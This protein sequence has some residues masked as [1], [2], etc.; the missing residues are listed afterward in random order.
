MCSKPS[1]NLPIFPDIRT[2]IPPLQPAPQT[3]RTPHSPPAPPFTPRILHPPPASPPFTPHTPAQTPPHSLTSPARPRRP[4][5]YTYTDIPHSPHDPPPSTP[6][7]SSSRSRISPRR[8]YPHAQA[9]NTLSCLHPADQPVTP[10]HRVWHLLRFAKTRIII[11]D[12]ER[13]PLFIR[14]HRINNQVV[15]P[16]QIVCPERP[17]QLL[18]AAPPHRIRN[19][20]QKRL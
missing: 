18:L 1:R 13:S 8:S 15:M 4:P 10:C 5:T 12:E 2:R 6:P 3:P 14:Q 20:P 19:S 11:I 17:R 9:S 7:L 16:V